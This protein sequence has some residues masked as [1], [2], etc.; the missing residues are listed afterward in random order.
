MS[1]PKLKLTF[2]QRVR[3]VIVR[4]SSHFVI[5]PWRNR[6]H[7]GSY[8]TVIQQDPE[9]ER[10]RV[11]G[12]SKG[13]KEASTGVV[14]DS[15][16]AA[17]SWRHPDLAAQLSNRPDAWQVM[18]PLW[19][20][21]LFNCTLFNTLRSQYS[22]IGTRGG[23]SHEHFLLYMF[24]GLFVWLQALPTSPGSPGSDPE[25]PPS[26]NY[27]GDVCDNIRLEPNNLHRFSVGNTMC[28][29]PH[30][31]LVDYLQRFWGGPRP[32]FLVLPAFIVAVPDK[33]DLEVGAMC[34]RSS[35]LSRT[36]VILSLPSVFI[37]AVFPHSSSLS[38]TNV[39]LR[40]RL[41][42]FIVTV[43]DKGDLEV[44]R[45]RLRENAERQ[46]IRMQRK[47]R[48]VLKKYAT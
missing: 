46:S 48:E 24:L 29:E 6:Q 30:W 39:I 18:P 22:G 31:V 1:T 20:V 15:S 4:M 26:L 38:R 23:L 27:S 43:P 21:N 9:A 14:T 36:T 33:G 35:S 32:I 17:L 19:P 42:A 25:T 5:G 44:G 8:S 3:R 28:A 45:F 13:E 40:C 16:F 10:Y 41:P 2:M 12:E 11:E 47:S 34:P 37:S 7:V